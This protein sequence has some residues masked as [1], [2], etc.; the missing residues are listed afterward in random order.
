VSENSSISGIG[1]LQFYPIIVYPP[2]I[3][4]PDGHSDD[5][6]QPQLPIVVVVT[7]FGIAVP[8]FSIFVA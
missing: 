8:P 1:F 6:T 7:L 4:V 5:G 2:A 3:G